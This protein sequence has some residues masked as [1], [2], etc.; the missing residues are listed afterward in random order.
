MRR[1][2]G[3][4]ENVEMA[5]KAVEATK[6]GEGLEK[7]ESEQ[8]GEVEIAGMPKRAVQEDIE[9]RKEMVEEQGKEEQR[10]RKEGKVEREVEVEVNGS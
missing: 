3:A 7:V 5:E 8:R 4:F 6:K 1:R 2:S 9:E 10:E